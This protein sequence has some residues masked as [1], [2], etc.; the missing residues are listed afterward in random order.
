MKRCLTRIVAA[1]LVISSL[2]AVCTSA[3]AQ[4][5]RMAEAAHRGTFNYLRAAPDEHSQI[6]EKMRHGTRF[7]VVGEQNGYY[8]VILEDGTQGWTAHQNVHFL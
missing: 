3:A 2:A 4:Q 1:C 5:V 6:I 7:E 8:A